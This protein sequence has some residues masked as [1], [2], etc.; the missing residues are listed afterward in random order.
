MKK[1]KALYFNFKW[2]SFVLFLVVISLYSPSWGQQNFSGEDQ[3]KVQKVL[4]IIERLEKEALEPQ[5]RPWKEVVLTEEELNA[6][7]AYRLR[8]DRVEMLQD[9]QIKLLDNNLIEG[10]AVFDLS[11][12]NLPDF[13]PRTAVVFFSTV[14]RVEGRRIYFD[15]KK[16]F[17]GPQE[18]SVNF[19]SEMI[20]QIALAHQAPPEGLNRSY[21]LPFGLKDIKTRKGL[22]IFYY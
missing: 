8:T 17:L 3:A 6:Y 13:V 16:I 18:L 10:K 4:Q 12:E 14:F 15:F 7:I 21:D 9:L 20:K 5:P 1:M 19:V 11:G 22:A 2:L